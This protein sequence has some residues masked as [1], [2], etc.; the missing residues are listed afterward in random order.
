MEPELYSAIAATSSQL[1]TSLNLY[2]TPGLGALPEYFRQ[3]N[4]AVLPQSGKKHS[5]LVNTNSP[6]GRGTP[7]AAES[8]LWAEGKPLRQTTLSSAC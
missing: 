8:A 2:R 4:H 6:S 7:S 5:A 3:S 1:I